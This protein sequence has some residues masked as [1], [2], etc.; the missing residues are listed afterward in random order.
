MNCPTTNWNVWFNDID[1][2]CI[3]TFDAELVFQDT[4][5]DWE[6]DLVDEREV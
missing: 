3:H 5:E 6:E 1:D 2:M 4:E